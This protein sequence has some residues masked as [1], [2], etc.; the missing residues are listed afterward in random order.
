MRRRVCLVHPE[1]K[2][3][4]AQ[5]QVNELFSTAAARRLRAQYG[6]SNG[7]GSSL[8]QEADI[9]TFEIKDDGKLD[10]MFGYTLH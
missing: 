6:G 10:M 5:V 7:S 9:V 8:T 3:R 2:R 4:S 1:I